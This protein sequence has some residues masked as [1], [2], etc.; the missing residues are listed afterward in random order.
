MCKAGYFLCE[1]QF[2]CKAV[3][4]RREAPSTPKIAESYRIPSLKRQP[5]YFDMPT[6][7]DTSIAYP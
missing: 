7:F 4:D 5:L 3:S 1:R 6:Y 2:L